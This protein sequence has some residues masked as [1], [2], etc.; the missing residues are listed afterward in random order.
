MN[1]FNLAK[2]YSTLQE[3]MLDPDVDQQAIEDTLE[4]IEGAIEEKGDSY[5]YIIAE[6]DA[7]ADMLKKESDRLAQKRQFVLNNKERLRATLLS[8]M[9]S[10]GKEKFK[11]DTHSFYISKHTN[12]EITDEAKIPDKFKSF[13]I[14]IDKTGLKKAM[15]DDIGIEG[16]EL[17]ESES[18]CIR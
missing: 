1:L 14:K 5:A 13:E 17:K 15:Q 6:L 18:V 7:S 3:M 4:A 2:N 8:A 16:A 10:T 12:V 11:T 9:K